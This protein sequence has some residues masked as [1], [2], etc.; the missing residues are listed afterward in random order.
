MEK[1]DDAA[2]KSALDKLEK[3][4][5]KLASTLYQSAGA[6][7]PGPEAGS[8]PS[9]SAGAPPGDSGDKKGKVIDAEFEDTP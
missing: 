6:G 3:E 2:V 9:A 5:H 4:F 1:Q 8:G 7:G